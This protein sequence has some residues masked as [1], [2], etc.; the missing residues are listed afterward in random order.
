MDEE[1][2]ITTFLSVPR[3]FEIL[4]VQTY[5]LCLYLVHKATNHRAMLPVSRS[6]GL[7]IKFPRT[8]IP[9][10]AAEFYVSTRNT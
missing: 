8:T 3:L 7:R 4:A 10:V 9:T 5:S 6:E 1:V 2:V